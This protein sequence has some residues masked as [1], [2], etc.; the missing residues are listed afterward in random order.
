MKLF[1][2]LKYKLQL[3]RICLWRW[4]GKN[5]QVWIPKIGKEETIQISWMEFVNI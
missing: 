5:P 2:E 3:S 4:G 1:C